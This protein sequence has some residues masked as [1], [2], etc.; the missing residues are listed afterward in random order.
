MLRDGLFFGAPNQF[1]YVGFN[2]YKTKAL[3]A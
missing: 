1:Y 3:V 2:A